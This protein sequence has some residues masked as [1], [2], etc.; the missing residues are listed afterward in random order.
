MG[1]YK[2]WQS[3]FFVFTFFLR[4][5]GGGGG[6]ELGKKK[7]WCRLL[8]QV[9]INKKITCC[10]LVHTNKLCSHGQIYNRP[11]TCRNNYV[12]AYYPWSQRKGHRKIAKRYPSLLKSTKFLVKSDFFCKNSDLRRYPLNCRVSY[13]LIF[14]APL[15]FLYPLKFDMQSFC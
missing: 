15:F 14:S 8:K 13:P 9:R 3:F 7:R 6:E 4:V 11:V 2:L 12:H 1:K 5:G 10:K